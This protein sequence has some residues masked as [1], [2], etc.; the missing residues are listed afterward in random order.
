MRNLVVCLGV[1]LAGC[2]SGLQEVAFMDQG[3]YIVSR[4]LVNDRWTANQPHVSGV[5]L[6]RAKLSSEELSKLRRD[7]NEHS[8]YSDCSVATE[9]TSTS[10]QSIA[11]LANGPIEA[12]VLGATVGTGLALSGDT[13]T[14]S[15]GNASASSKSKAKIGAKRR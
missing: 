5:F 1:L 10:D 13:V 11:S 14:Q 4:S 7:G 6:C 3:R 15:G 8:Q 9:Y 12:V 2:S